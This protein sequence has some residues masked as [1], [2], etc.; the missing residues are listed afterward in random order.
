[1][2]DLL[3]HTISDIVNA[4]KRRER[5]RVFVFHTQT[6]LIV[7]AEREPVQHYEWN[8]RAQDLQYRKDTP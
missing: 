3:S 8:S 7:Y 5:R 1:M 4:K 6:P 2:T